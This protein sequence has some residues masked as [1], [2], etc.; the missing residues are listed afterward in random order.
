MMNTIKLTTLGALG[1]ALGVGGS[2]T[3]QPAE[4]GAA[5]VGVER[6]PVLE[7]QPGLESGATRDIDL[8]LCLDTSNSMDGLIDSARQRLWALVNELALA[9]PTP[10]LRVALLTYG[11]PGFGEDN[12]WVRTQ[13]PLTDD[14][15]MV[16]GS[17]YTSE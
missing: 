3:P 6:A 11:S 17:R 8:A 16:S 7:V 14:L 5:P 13:V 2:G 1:L 12:G 9:E 4:D 10:R 15:D